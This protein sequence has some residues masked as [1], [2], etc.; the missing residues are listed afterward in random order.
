MT[1]VTRTP[2]Q[3]QPGAV[4]NT[5]RPSK[6]TATTPTTSDTVLTVGLVLVSSVA[7]GSIFG[8]ALANAHQMGS[9]AQAAIS[10]IVAVAAAAIG[11]IG[12]IFR[13]RHPRANRS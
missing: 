1:T 4:P 10:A 9:I 5:R 3:N 6:D 7:I 8:I 13:R 11:A 12:A 2:V